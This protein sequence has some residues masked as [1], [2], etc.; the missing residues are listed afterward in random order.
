MSLGWGKLFLI[1]H[2]AQ[3]SSY[4]KVT[5]VAARALQTVANLLGELGENCVWASTDFG[6]LGA[7]G[8]WSVSCWDWLFAT[9][10]EQF[11]GA[12][13]E[14]DEADGAER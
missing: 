12:G 3:A 10:D 2:A 5:T 14:C 1:N 4:K 13:S 8:F 7:S 11:N 9:D 6:L